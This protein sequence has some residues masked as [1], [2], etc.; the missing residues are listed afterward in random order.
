MFNKTKT[1]E[2]DQQELSPYLPAGYDDEKSPDFVHPDLRPYW[3]LDQDQEH[4]HLADAR[5]FEQ[6]VWRRGMRQEYLRRVAEEGWPAN[7]E[8][9]EYQIRLEHH[10]SFVPPRPTPEDRP[11]YAHAVR[12]TF[13]V[14]RL[15]YARQAEEHH[16]QQAAARWCD[17]GQHPHPTTSRRTIRS[18]TVNGCDECVPGV[19]ARV[20]RLHE[21]LVN[22][23]GVTR[24]QRN[25]E[26]VAGHRDELLTVPEAI[27]L[28][29]IAAANLIN[30]GGLR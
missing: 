25:D 6:W 20:T 17:L 13:A 18:V 14:Q 11:A 7:L 15:H 29:W 30:A 21:E 26:W 12:E 9:R 24:G 3:G 5:R 19:E 8:E 16:A 23:D 2:D 28:R 22:D 10:E 1:T 4:A 27:D